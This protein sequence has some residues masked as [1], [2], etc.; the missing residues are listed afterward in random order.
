M[1]GSAMVLFGILTMSKAAKENK[2]AYTY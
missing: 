2:V 1:T